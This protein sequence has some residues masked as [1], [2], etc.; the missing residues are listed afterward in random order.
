[1][2]CNMLFVVC[3]WSFMCVSIVVFFINVLFGN[4]FMM[5]ILDFN[6]VNWIFGWNRESKIFL[7]I[8]DVVLVGNKMRR[9]GLTFEVIF[10]RYRLTREVYVRIVFVVVYGFFDGWRFLSYYFLLF[11][12]YFLIIFKMFFDVFSG[13]GGITSF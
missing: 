5:R 7:F 1:M 2:F 12:L 11:N 13:N 8:F 6:L 10:C 4:F 9:F 3:D